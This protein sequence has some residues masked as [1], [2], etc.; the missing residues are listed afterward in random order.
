M[1]ADTCVAMDDW[2]QNP[3]ANS[4]LNLQLLPCMDNKTAQATLKT[5][6][7]ATSHLIDIVNQYILDVANKDLPPSAGILYHNQSGPLVPILCN[8]FSSD[9][10]DRKCASTETD[11]SNVARVSLISSN[12]YLRI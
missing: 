3:A 2:L 8:P 12:S 7:L 6:K 10:K 9:M 5:S 1:V 11:F 4:A